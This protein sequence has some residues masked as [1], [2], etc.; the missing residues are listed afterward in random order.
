MLTSHIPQRFNP[1]HGFRIL[2]EAEGRVGTSSPAL[3]LKAGVAY[4]GPGC[5]AAT[6]RLRQVALYTGILF[7]ANQLL[8]E[9]NFSV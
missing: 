5:S 1:L 8:R 2:K 3:P 7:I 6:P 4:P 9:Y